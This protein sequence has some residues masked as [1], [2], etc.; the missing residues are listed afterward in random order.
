[1]NDRECLEFFEANPVPEFPEIALKFQALSNPA[2]KSD[3]FRYYYLYVKGGLFIDSDAIPMQNINELLEDYNFVSVKS[4]IEGSMANGFIACAPGNKILLEALRDAYDTSDATLLADYHLLC[5][6]FYTIVNKHV[7]SGVKFLQE[8]EERDW[9]RFSTM[10]MF[11]ASGQ[12]ALIH[13][14]GDKIVPRYPRWN[15]AIRILPV[16]MRALTAPLRI[17][18]RLAKKLRRVAASGFNKDLPTK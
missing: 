17:M 15:H 5:R 2:H 8:I 18:I 7:D 13:Y 10:R 1:L 16:R 11:D 12:V 6:N 4:F 14:F 9:I 3:L